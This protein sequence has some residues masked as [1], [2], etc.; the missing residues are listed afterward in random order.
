MSKQR[1]TF[2]LVVGWVDTGDDGVLADLHGVNHPV[3]GQ[4][5]A[6]ITSRVVRIDHDDRGNVC[7]IETRNTVYTRVQA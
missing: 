3:L 7:E 1:A 5:D 4:E 6:V 2:R